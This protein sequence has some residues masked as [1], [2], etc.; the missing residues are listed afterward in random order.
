[1]T[2]KTISKKI[3]L[4]TSHFKL[5]NESCSKHNEEKV[6]DYYI[7]EMP[8]AVV[9]AALT[10]KTNKGKQK[11]ILIKQYRHTVK[12]T[13]LE[14]PAGYM[15]PGEKNPSK[16]AERELVEETGYKVTSMIKLGEAF[17]SAGFMNNKVYFFLGKDAEKIQDQSLDQNEEIDIKPTE[18]KK[19]LA[20]LHE[21][22]IK[23]LGSM[24]CL[25]L[26]ELYLSKENQ[27]NDKTNKPSKKRGNR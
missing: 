3:I 23:D 24:T 5:T 18:I 25:M 9:V 27:N 4:K 15:N 21:G 1:M 19:A 16:A 6:K 7:C 13:H 17:T 26:A 11:I 8:N 22:K 2:W 20:L 12:S 10:K 14:L